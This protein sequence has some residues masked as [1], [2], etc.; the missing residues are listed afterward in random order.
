MTGLNGEARV[1]INSE[2]EES[3][4]YKVNQTL[5]QSGAVSNVEISNDHMILMGASS[6][7]ALLYMHLSSKFEFIHSSKG[8]KESHADITSDKTWMAVQIENAG[9]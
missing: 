6:N 7:E 5:W 2:I 9:I 3:T 8:I 1:Y 4:L